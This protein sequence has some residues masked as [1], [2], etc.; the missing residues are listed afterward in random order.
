MVTVEIPRTAVVHDAVQY[1]SQP[2]DTSGPTLIGLVGEGGIGKTVIAGMVHDHLQE[3]G[4]RCAFVR[5][6]QTTNRSPLGMLGTI[7]RQ[8]SRAHFRPFLRAVSE[9][10]GKD[11]LLRRREFEDV[12]G[13]FADRMRALVEDDAPVFVGIDNLDVVGQDF[14]RWMYETLAAIGPEM[15]LYV[16]TRHPSYVD[17]GRILRVRPLTRT[18]IESLCGQ[19]A[20][21]DDQEAVDRV[22]QLTHA[23]PLLAA[24]L[25]Q[26]TT[27][28]M[29]AD[30]LS[31]HDFGAAFAKLFGR[32][33]DDEQHLLSMLVLAR[34]RFTIAMMEAASETGDIS[35]GA[36]HRVQRLPFVNS[37]D[38]SAGLRLHDAVVPYIAELSR[39]DQEA[40]RQTLLRLVED[41]YDVRLMNA[42][43]RGERRILVSERLGCL[44]RADAAGAI[45]DLVREVRDSIERFDFDQVESLLGTIDRDG[46]PESHDVTISLLRV[47]AM[48]ARF[49]TPSAARMLDDVG[50]R[51]RRLVSRVA[52]AEWLRL[53]A[54]CVS[55]P[56]P[57]PHGDIFEAIQ[58]LRE[59]VEAARMAGSRHLLDKA[60]FDLA[61]ALR[62]VGRNLEALSLYESIRQEAESV[63]Q[64]V[65]AVRCLE[66]ASQTYR[67]MQDLERAR[68][69]LEDSYRLRVEHNITVGKGVA[70]YYSAN[71]YR[72]TGDFVSARR[73]YGAA[74]AFF[75]EAGDDNNRCALY[76]DWAW[77]EY[78]DG[79]ND[80]ARDLQSQSFELAS[81]YRFGA[82]LAEHWHTMY[83]L[84]RDAG[85]TGL[86]YSYLENGLSEAKRSNNMYMILDCLMHTAQRALAEHE[87]AKIDECL[88][89]IEAYEL[90]GC[91]IHV[92][93]GRTLMVLG[94]A[95]FIEGRLNEAYAAWRD[96][97]VI[98][99]KFGNSRSNVELFDDIL[100][101][102]R[103]N[104]LSV[105]V[106]LGY[107]DTLRAQWSSEGLDAGFVEVIRI[108]D[109][110]A[111]MVARP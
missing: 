70:D 61:R 22:L 111:Q 29:N 50:V 38:S 8:L 46:L 87:Y 82:E 11:D 94:D 37:Y 76:A 108:C 95:K 85:N 86:A 19:A 92:F 96:G 55:N 81:T 75:R 93:R 51:L 4:R 34:A 72:D 74:E 21:I 89:E 103:A 60:R 79:A 25:V 104:I 53:R 2:T 15:R 42:T 58:L 5:L 36:Y 102:R 56:V 57:V 27:D 98:V 30:L 6:D 73:R 99:A 109:E 1:L 66:E 39:L 63:G 107:Q 20:G 32:L 110:A 44:V 69:T 33:S 54:R 52:T 91:G 101:T 47:E 18:D 40:Q 12:V 77:L 45:D 88:A 80:T 49:D 13:V 41:Y 100:A 59:A 35:T 105:I 90:R 62:S 23:N 9:Y 26:A 65:L 64:F 16:T 10:Q 31:S 3:A 71:T 67:L 48:I 83:H 28:D 43:D 78:L 24:T 7:A 106:D 17:V 14:R 68:A 97:L 84:E